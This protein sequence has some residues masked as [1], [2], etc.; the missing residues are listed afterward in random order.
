[1]LGLASNALRLCL[2]CHRYVEGNT[3]DVYDN[4]WKVRHGDD[5]AAVPVL[6]VTIYGRGLSLLDDSGCYVLAA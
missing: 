3:A 2:A 4:G 5:P 6:L 1:M